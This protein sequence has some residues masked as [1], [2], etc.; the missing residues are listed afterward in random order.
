[1]GNYR[2]PPNDGMAQR[3][4][5]ARHDGHKEVGTPSSQSVHDD[6]IRKLV[7][8]ALLPMKDVECA[9]ERIRAIIDAAVKSAD[10]I[11]SR[12]SF[13]DN[14]LAEAQRAA[15]DGKFNESGLDGLLSW[16]GRSA[17]EDARRDQ[18]FDKYSKMIRNS[19]VN[20][21]RGYDNTNKSPEFDCYDKWVDKIIANFDKAKNAIGT[22]EDSE[23][24]TTVLFTRIL[25]GD[26]PIDFPECE[27][28]VRRIAKSCVSDWSRKNLHYTAKNYYKVKILEE[29]LHSADGNATLAIES[30]I[31]AIPKRGNAHMVALTESIL[32]RQENQASHDDTLEQREIKADVD[33]L[34]NRLYGM[35]KGTHYHKATRQ[36]FRNLELLEYVMLGQD[37]GTGEDGVL[38]LWA[39]ELG[40]PVRAFRRW[41][42]DAIDEMAECALEMGHTNKHSRQLAGRRRARMLACE[43]IAK[44]DN[45]KAYRPKGKPQT[46]RISHKEIIRFLF[47]ELEQT[48]EVRD[49]RDLADH[50]KYPF[51]SFKNW[52]SKAMDQFREELK[53]IEIDDNHIQMIMKDLN[54]RAKKGKQQ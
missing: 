44:L 53:N 18:F 40:V 31:E 41:C 15:E 16:F 23:K 39:K 17:K 28:L 12:N 34:L 50:L 52:H 35:L 36:T 42:A 13:F 19:L 22:D 49:I 37:E 11:G 43:T 21:F 30:Q 32:R 5:G 46:D 2:Q 7:A 1:M 26:A 4:T 33:A 54:P 45:D 8:T 47:D 20:T 27:A 25:N 6:G 48:G 51:G 10:I 24:Q 9:V 29:K 3:E 14:L 38:A